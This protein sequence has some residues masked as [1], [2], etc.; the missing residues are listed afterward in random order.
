LTRVGYQGLIGL[1]NG[2]LSPNQNFQDVFNA[3][4]A[5]PSDVELPECYNV[6]DINHADLTVINE[7]QRH[8]EE[9][10]RPTLARIVLPYGITDEYP[11]S[12]EACKAISPFVHPKKDRVL[13]IA[14]HVR[15]GEIYANAPARLL[16]NSYYVNVV[17]RIII[18]LETQGIEYQ[19]N[20][21]TEVSNREIV[22]D[23][24]HPIVGD[25]ISTPVIINSNLNQ[26]KD[27]DILPHLV[28][29]INEPTIDCLSSIA[30]ANIIVMSRSSFSYVA[31]ILS[32]QTSIVICY[33]FWHAALSSWICSSEDGSFDELSFVKKLRKLSE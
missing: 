25:A 18:I 27:F 7:V 3:L 26:I 15:R 2:S 19:V 6:I 13:K 32:S 21:H 33:P 31:A 12:Y 24:G 11:D 14:V 22:I 1:E 30:T 29:R 16:P 20:L 10:S 4:F 8:A 17:N 28:K 9:A 5:I 23:P